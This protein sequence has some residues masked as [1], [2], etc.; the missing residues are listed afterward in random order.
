[1]HAWVCMVK[2][3]RERNTFSIA[4][5][6]L[7][8][9]LAW[10]QWGQ[11]SAKRIV[12]FVYMAKGIYKRP[13]ISGQRVGRLLVLKEL[14]KRHNNHRVFLCRCDCGSMF[15]SVYSNLHSGN[16]ESCGCNVKTQRGLY[17]HPLY[18]V[19]RGM[20][21]RCLDH[22]SP[23]FSDYGSRWITVCDR[24]KVFLN[25]YNDMHV[26]Y[27]K[28]LSIERIDNDKGYSKE[29]CMWAT[30]KQQQANRRDTQHITINGETKCLAEWA[31]IFH[32][33]QP[34]ANWRYKKGWD[35]NKVFS[36]PL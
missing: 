12:P 8:A 3:G 1:M 32:V 26:S 19:W 33:P 18:S 17:K 13:D 29:N 25:F 30:M 35:L 20:M 21:R 5:G 7:L 22:R 31:R 14:D 15:Q 24:W 11:S 23:Q 6:I 36:Q 28:G 4:Y 27:E 34:T 10:H 9:L 16:T 2:L